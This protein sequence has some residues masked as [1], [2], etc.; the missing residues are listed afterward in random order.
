MKGR[1]WRGVSFYLPYEMGFVKNFTVDSENR[2]RGCNFPE[3]FPEEQYPD[4]KWIEQHRIPINCTRSNYKLAGEE[5]TSADI[6]DEFA[7]DH[8]VWAQAFIE[9]W[10]VL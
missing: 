3:V 2:P 9:G 8:E 4:P 5:Q 10:Q 7:D 6:V 1:A